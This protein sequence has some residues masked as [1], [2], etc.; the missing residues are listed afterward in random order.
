MGSLY[1]FKSKGNDDIGLSPT[2]SVVAICR[3]P[4]RDELIDEL[5]ADPRDFDMIFVEPIAR[6]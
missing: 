3:G 5:L 4:R 1:K 2:S 6:A